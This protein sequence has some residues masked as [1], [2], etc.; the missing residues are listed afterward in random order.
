MHRNK[1]ETWLLLQTSVNRGIS[2]STISAQLPCLLITHVQSHKCNIY[3]EQAA[4][5]KLYDYK[6]TTAYQVCQPVSC[7]ISRK[8]RFYSALQN[9]SISVIILEH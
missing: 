1:P 6:S 4:Y 8:A 2:G 5:S 3:L 9:N 7:I